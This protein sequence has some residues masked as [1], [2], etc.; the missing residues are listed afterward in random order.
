MSETWGR[1]RLRAQDRRQEDAQGVGEEKFDCVFPLLFL[2]SDFTKDPRGQG[3]TEG[4]SSLGFR[5][6]K[7]DDQE[8]GMGRE[9]GG[10]FWM[11]NTCAPVADS[12]R[13]LAKTITIL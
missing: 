1:K 9:M 2:E 12:C 8:D 4:P 7:K 6:F 10:E 11:G 3:L 13:C 5:G